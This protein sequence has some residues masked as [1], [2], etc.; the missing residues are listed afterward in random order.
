MP[1]N[2]DE[3]ILQ[4]Y[5]QKQD[6]RMYVS[7]H[8]RMQCAYRYSQHECGRFSYR[9][10]CERVCGFLSIT[11]H[12]NELSSLPETVWGER[13]SASGIGYTN[14]C[15]LTGYHRYRRLH[16]SAIACILH[17][18]KTQWILWNIEEILQK[19]FNFPRGLVQKLRSQTY[20]T[21]IK[22]AEEYISTILSMQNMTIWNISIN[23]IEL[24]H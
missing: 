6:I 21:T 22:R 20:A 12:Y 24:Q 14:H 5:V 15:S 19:M 9:D 3:K 1:F 13:S 17:V 10:S 11:I 4:T 2:F 18:Y 8:V 7:I 16:V 23:K